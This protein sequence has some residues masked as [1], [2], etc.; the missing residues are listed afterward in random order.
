MILWIFAVG[1]VSILTID[2]FPSFQTHL[3]HQFGIDQFIRWVNYF[4]EVYDFMMR[5]LNLIWMYLD[6]LI[7]L[8]KV[9]VLYLILFYQTLLFKEYN[10]KRGIDTK[11]KLSWF[12][13]FLLDYSF[14]FLVIFI[15]VVFSLFLDVLLGVSEKFNSLF[16]ELFHFL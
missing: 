15:Y 16:L 13:R 14:Y 2:P 4:L 5:W 12:F 8:V 3:F 10:F 1:S 7:R 6:W 11:S 9:K